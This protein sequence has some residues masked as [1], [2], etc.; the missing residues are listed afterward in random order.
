MKIK[1]IDGLN[2]IRF[3]ILYAVDSDFTVEQY[4]QLQAGE[5]VDVSH[6]VGAKLLAM[7]KAETLEKEIEEVAENGG[8]L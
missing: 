8:T 4:R 5:A 1:A 2:G 7:G 3:V 6:P